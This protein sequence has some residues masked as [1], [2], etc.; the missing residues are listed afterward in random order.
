VR[1]VGA[2][3]RWLRGV[4]ARLA[5]TF[6]LAAVVA[7]LAGVLAF[8]VILTDGLNTSVDSSLQ[9]SANALIADIRSGTI[10]QEGAMPR[11][12]ESRRR[13][14]LAGIVAVYNPQG[15]LAEAEP[16]ALPAPPPTDPSGGEFRTAH[17]AGQRFRFLTQRVRLR[18]GSWLVVVGQNLAPVDDAKVDARHALYA[19]VPAAVI[20][21]ALGAWLLAGAALKPVDRMRADAQRLSETNEA[22]NITVPATSDSLNALARTFNTLLDRLHTSL[23]RQRSLVADAGHELRTPLAVLQT[24]LDTAVRPSRS[25]EDLVD[26]IRHAQEEVGRLATLS[27]NLLLLAQADGPARLISTDLTDVGELLDATAAAHRDRFAAAQVQLIARTV[28][29]DGPL[30]ADLDPIAVRR[31]LDN[32]LTNALRHTPAGGQVELTAALIPS[33]RGNRLTITVVDTGSGFPPAF[34]PHAFER[35]TRADPSRSRSRSSATAGSGLGLAIVETLVAEHSGSVSAANEPGGGARVE[36][37]F[38][39]DEFDGDVDETGES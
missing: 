22:G 2:A 24:E 4:R 16:L 21:S 20:L 9:T 15:R 11:V 27:E 35:F 33:D 32:L 7:A 38:P 34:L 36:I 13:H 17:Y 1:A 18:S 19:V 30:V 26:S 31:M 14:Y 25:R 39:L 29:S 8:T 12:D 37:S 28:T 6:V 5:S 23:E 10:G 3:V